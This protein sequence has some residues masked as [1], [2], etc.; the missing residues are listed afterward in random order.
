MGDEQGTV[1]ST[2]DEFI[3]KCGR[4]AEQFLNQFSVGGA[5]VDV[6]YALVRDAGLCENY[7]GRRGA[8]DDAEV[9][10]SQHWRDVCRD[11]G[12]RRLSEQFRPHDG[13]RST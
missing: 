6:E 13:G 11:R 5:S 1:D 4:T 7:V 12:S 9:P 8:F 2:R 10:L 3:Y